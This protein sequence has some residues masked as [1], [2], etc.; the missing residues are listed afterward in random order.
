MLAWVLSGGALAVALATWV[1]YLRR[2]PLERVPERPTTHQ[3]FFGFAALLAVFGVVEGLR[4]EPVGA[5]ANVALALS[6]WGA[7][8]F[9]VWLL[10][11]G[12]VPDGQLVVAVGDPLPAFAAVD[13]TGAAPAPIQRSGGPP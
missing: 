12:P 6:T 4:L 1:D 9:F 10:R 11:W 5:A 2:I 7:G 8:G 3:A 13:S